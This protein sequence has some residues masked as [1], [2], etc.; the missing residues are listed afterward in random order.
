MSRQRER[1]AD[2]ERKANTVYDRK[3]ASDPG[4][5]PVNFWKPA[6]VRRKSGRQSSVLFGTKRAAAALAIA[7]PMIAAYLWPHAHLVTDMGPDYV[8]SRSR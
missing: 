3:E 6:R 4:E 1:G 7:A 2:A 8:R 5:A